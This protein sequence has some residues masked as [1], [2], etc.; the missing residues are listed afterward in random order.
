MENLRGLLASLKPPESDMGGLRAI[1]G[2]Q[3]VFEVEKLK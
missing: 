1:N 3:K 2:L